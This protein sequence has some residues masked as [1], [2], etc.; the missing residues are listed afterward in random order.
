MFNALQIV[1]LVCWAN[2]VRFWKPNSEAIEQQ[3]H[4]QNAEM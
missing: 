2:C 4:T 3:H 1:S